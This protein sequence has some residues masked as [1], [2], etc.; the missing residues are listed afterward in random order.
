MR[1]AYFALIAASVLLGLAGCR[2]HGGRCMTNGLPT[3]CANAPE[4][5]ASCGPGGVGGQ[6]FCQACG[7]RGCA[8]CGH[9]SCNACGGRGCAS[10]GGRRAEAFTP[11]PPTGAITY[12]Y[13]TLRGP[14]DF[15]ARNPQS[16]GP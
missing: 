16:I 12:P 14:R 5:C 15:L 9:A 11:G 4:N 7:G 3:S 2:S 10:C 13:Y 1:H 6:A 8:S